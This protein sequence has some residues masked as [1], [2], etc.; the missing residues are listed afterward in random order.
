MGL[1][2]SPPQDNEI[3]VSVFGPG[4]GECILI[5]LG[6]KEWL[7]VDSCLDPE[8]KEPYPLIYL[9][10]L[11]IDPK[12]SIKYILATHWHDDH[13]RGLSRIVE[14]C[15]DAEFICSSAFGKKEFTTLVDAYSKHTML[16]DSGIEEFNRILTYNLLR[17]PK[18]S[19][20]LASGDRPLYTS[21][22]S[23]PDLRYSIYSLSP[24][25]HAMLNA[26]LDIAR[27]LPE[28]KTTKIRFPNIQPNNTCVVLLIIIGE[29][30]LL[31]GADLEEMGD[32][33]MGWMNIIASQTRPAI[34]AILYKISHHGSPNA[35]HQDIWTSLLD[36]YFHAVLTPFTHGNVYLPR[37]TDLRRIKAN[38]G[39][40]ETYITSLPR[41]I[42]PITRNS[43]VERTIRES[44]I[45][46]MRYNNS[47]GH[48]RF[49]LNAKARPYTWHVDLDGQATNIENLI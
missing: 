20:K 15:K 5:H 24:S 38:T 33:N 7:V 14:V 18:K 42:R 13:I 37:E 22:N 45:K 2:N 49:R 21:N 47:H 43:T 23:C 3:E 31:L 10:K 40:N 9:N 36:G 26:V 19:I 8:H 44:G 39:T 29:L 4:F 17:R 35:D 32:P 11:G 28:A 6:N 41:W 48:V 1:S 27:L 25:D 46:L 34:K 12:Y 16:Q 30:A